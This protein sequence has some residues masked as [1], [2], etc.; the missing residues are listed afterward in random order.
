MHVFLGA[1]EYN[2]TFV[3]HFKFFYG[4]LQVGTRSQG[5]QKKRIKD[6]LNA[7]LEDFNILT[8]SWEQTGQNRAKWHILIRKGADDYDAKRVCK[9][10]QKHKECKA[11]AK[12]SS[13]ESTSSYSE[14]TCSICNRQFGA[15]I[16]SISHQ[17]TQ[18]HTRTMNT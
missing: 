2:F 5:G 18:Q 7:S 6:T 13:S 12:G 4:E 16:G 11:R 15:K 8:E 10:E 14:F 9:A 17:R 1:A 3:P